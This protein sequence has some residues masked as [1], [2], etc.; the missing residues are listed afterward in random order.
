MSD[1]KMLERLIE[2]FKKDS[3]ISKRNRELILSFIQRCT[4]DG[5]KAITLIKHIYRFKKIVIWLDKDLDKTSKEDLQKLVARINASD[6]K[7]WTKHSFRV[8]IKKFYKIMEGNDDDPDYYPK[9]VRWIKTTMRDVEL[10]NPTELLKPDDVDKIISSCDKILH[11]AIIRFLF[12]TGVRVDELLSIKIKDVN[13][14][15]GYVV[16][17]GTK[18]KYSK[19]TVP[20]V[21]SMPLMTQWLELHPDCDPECF[22]WT[23]RDSK[24]MSYGH[25][26]YII[27]EAAR[28]A[29][30]KGKKINPHA[31]RKSSATENSKHLKYPELCTYH[32]WKIG[33][34][35]PML[36][37]RYTQEDIK[38]AFQKKN[39]IIEHKEEQQSPIKKCKRCNQIC[40]KTSSFCPKCGFMFSDTERTSKIRSLQKRRQKADALFD[41]ISQHPQLLEMFEDALKKNDINVTK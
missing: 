12:E 31:W 37:I 33:S 9:K 15:E 40:E 5:M 20:I 25:L 38:K 3:S 6:Y 24:K 23:T 27:N 39:G 41:L 14:Q 21:Q 29:G 22:V 19:R 8:I 13:L 35:I 36:Y 30:I 32:G 28:K 10:V 34:E 17:N 26:R 1:E 2:R 4:A 11:K 18:N 7:E 16:I